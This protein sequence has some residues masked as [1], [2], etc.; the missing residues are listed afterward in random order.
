MF[1]I[2]NCLFL[3]LLCKTFGSYIENDFHYMKRRST[4]FSRVSPHKI[5]LF[6][7]HNFHPWI[8]CPCYWKSYFIHTHTHTEKTFGGG[9]YFN[10]FILPQG[11]GAMQREIE[12]SIKHQLRRKYNHSLYIHSTQDLCNASNIFF[13][14]FE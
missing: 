3:F 9:G 2:I 11:Q 12:T 13:R 1:S 7:L 4:N 8:P 10:F 5:K 6:T 14:P